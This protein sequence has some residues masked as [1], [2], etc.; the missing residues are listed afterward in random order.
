MTF[1]RLSAAAF[2]AIVVLSAARI[3]GAQGSCDVVI[4]LD[5]LTPQGIVALGVGYPVADG[6]F[7]GNSTVIGFEGVYGPDPIA[8]T[9]LAGEF[10]DALDDKTGTLSLFVADMAFLTGPLPLV[11]CVFEYVSGAA[12]PAP[13]DFTIGDPAFPDEPIPPPPFPPVPAV[14]VA[15]VTQ[16]IEVCGD[17][18]REGAEECD[19]GNAADGDCCSSSCQFDLAGTAC[20]DGSVCTA[21]ESCDGSGTCV[22]GSVLDCDDGV[23]CTYDSCDPIAGCESVTEPM[24]RGECGHLRKSKLG[25]RDHATNDTAD[26]LKLK[27]QLGTASIGDPSADTD[28]AICIFDEVSG[29]PVLVSQIEVPAGAPWTAAAGGSFRYDDPARANDGVEKIR[30]KQKP[31]KRGKISL[32][33]KGAGLPLPGPFDASQ[34]LSADPGVVIEVQNSAGNCWGQTYDDSHGVMIHR[35]DGFKAKHP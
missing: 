6:E 15:S 17:G 27:T 13:G 28:Y 19:D 31:G 10:F 2:T 14:S 34:Y 11:S 16:R 35:P 22:A 32:L 23:F 24:P 20:P 21:D 12:C 26:R 9:P 4:Q 8:C 5:D 33:G 18:F 7:I 25:L 1:P 3:A 29:N 30:L